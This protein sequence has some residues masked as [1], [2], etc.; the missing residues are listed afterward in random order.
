MKDRTELYV[1]LSFGTAFL[2]VMALLVAILMV[3]SSGGL[4]AYGILALLPIALLLAFVV[5]D[6]AVDYYKGEK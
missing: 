1:A 3:A 4:R 6:C 2:G 5:T